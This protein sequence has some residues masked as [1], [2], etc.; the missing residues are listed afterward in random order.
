MIQ[1]LVEKIRQVRMKQSKE[2]K[3]VRSGKRVTKVAIKNQVFSLLS[4]RFL[5]FTVS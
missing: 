1:G 5:V 3:R 4:F 2:R